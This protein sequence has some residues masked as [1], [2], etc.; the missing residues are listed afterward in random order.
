MNNPNRKTAYLA[1]A[2]ACRWA[3]HQEWGA[4][5]GLMIDRNCYG[6]VSVCALGAMALRRA[7]VDRAHEDF[8]VVYDDILHGS[9]AEALGMGTLADARDVS[10]RFDDFVAEANLP[11]DY[12]EAEKVWLQAAAMFDGLASN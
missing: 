6:E 5:D 1:A 10:D 4:V 8:D 2:E 12:G 11:T 9:M 7:L 3:A